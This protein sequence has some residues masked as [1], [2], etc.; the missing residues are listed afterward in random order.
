M[1]WVMWSV[2]MAAMMLPSA[3]PMILVHRRISLDREE[4]G[5]AENVY[6]IAAYLTAWAVFSLVATAVQWGLQSLSVMSSMLVIADGWIAAAL[7]VAAG[8]YQFTSYKEACLEKCRTPFGFL[9]TEWR[10]GK[11]GAFDMGLRHGS[12]CVGC[13]WA[14]MAALFAFGVMHL[15]AILL[16]TTAVAAEK[17]LPFGK[18]VKWVL[19]T[20]FILWGL[21]LSIAA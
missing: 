15:G 17:L 18:T 10:P 16:L 11:V 19:G 21:A 4:R 3:A 2:M 12:Y 1:V 14:L 6:F 13:C 7:L 9:V 5:T 20:V 8:I